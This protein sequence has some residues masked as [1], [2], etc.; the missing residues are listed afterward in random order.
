MAA[1]S[2]GSAPTDIHAHRPLPD[3]SD[4]A[5]AVAVLARAQQDTTW[6]R[7]QVGNRLRSLLREYYPA[8]LAA[9]V[10]W[11]N[12]LCRPAALALLKVA[13][14]PSGREILR[15]EW[16]HHPPQVEKALGRQMLA[17]LAQ[18]EAA[19]TAVDDL[20][21]PQRR[22]SSNTRTRRSS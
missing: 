14:R 8:A 1:P 21:R 19:C 3:D 22:P 15:A 2:A 7:R 9:V 12:G 17:L 6:N 20:D 5:R 11:K 4:Q 18:P 10:H 16:A 13:P